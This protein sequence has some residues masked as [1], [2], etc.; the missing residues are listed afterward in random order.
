MGMNCLGVFDPNEVMTAPSPPSTAEAEFPVDDSE[1]CLQEM[2][3]LCLDPS[4]SLS[5]SPDSASPGNC[6]VPPSPG[7]KRR[8]TFSNQ[9]KACPPPGNGSFKYFCFV[10]ILFTNFLKTINK[11]YF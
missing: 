6:G 4:P 5:E 9:V 8:V 10:L 7:V 2:K 1:H 11:S 3:G